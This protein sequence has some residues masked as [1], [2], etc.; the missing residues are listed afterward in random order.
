MI[1]SRKYLVLILLSGILF[2]F[3]TCKKRDKI[4]T[5]PGL[6]LTFSAD[7]IFFDTVF[8]TIGSVTKRLIVYNNNDGKLLVSQI[9]LAGGEESNY[10][11]NVDGNPSL[12]IQ[13]VE[14]YGHDSLFIF[15][16]V[17]IDPDNQN[18]PFVVSDSVL[19]N[20]NGNQQNVQ[21]VT[22]G[23]NAR[24]FRNAELKGSTVWDSLLPF[25]I[26][27]HL[28]IDTSSSLIVLPGCKL[29]FHKN[30]YIS[31]SY[32]ASLRIFGNLEHPVT[33]QGD[34]LD[35]F[36]KDLPGQWTGILL[37]SG[38]KGHEIDHALIKN[39]VFG[40][41]IDE[42]LSQPDPMLKLDNTVI[43]NTTA[44]AIFAYASS[45]S[46]TNCV[47]VNCRGSALWIEKGGT[48]N[49]K[50]LTIGNYWGNS[51]RIAPSL[52]IRNYSYDTT[53]NE[54]PGPLT[55]TYF[56]NCII[57]GS[58]V[59]EFLPD[60]MQGVPFELVFDHCLLRSQVNMSDPL[61]FIGCFANEDP[62][63]IDPQAFDLRID[64]LSPV[65]GRGI[66]MGVPFDID[67]VDRGLTPD[68][69]AYEWI[70]VR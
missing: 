56:G 27:G 37:E 54:S 9:R 68:L 26:Y 22:W 64:S 19:F 31:V 51:A 28:R 60:T 70:P 25:V 5:D 62:L 3:V 65:I 29:F 45:I 49:F 11:M 6:R 69:G 38:S 17:T 23:Q 58:D 2:F 47:L 59:N 48:Y 50:Q 24:F 67:G 14:I 16:R 42:K 21:L 32:D 20:V 36:Y 66:D 8:T 63:F 12:S 10:R 30:A 15:I 34:R 46:S 18:T 13:D 35:P 53:G 43:R 44:D 4:D 41:M 7:T 33:L 39:S 61:H 57:F 1:P 55:N 52:Y 40:I